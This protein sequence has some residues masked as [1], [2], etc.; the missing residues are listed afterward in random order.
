MRKPLERTHILNISSPSPIELK[1][2]KPL[3]GVPEAPSLELLSVRQSDLYGTS[4]PTEG[5]G[6]SLRLPW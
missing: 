6:T 3:Q 5:L 1:E 4:R 2:R